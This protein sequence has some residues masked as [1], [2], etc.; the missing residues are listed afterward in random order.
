MEL[1]SF[2]HENT[3]VASSYNVQ[4]TMLLCKIQ[5]KKCQQKYFF[6]H[7]NVVKRSGMLAERRN[8]KEAVNITRLFVPLFIAFER[9][10]C[11]S[12]T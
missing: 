12:I 9:R 10:L 11:C 3:I 2:I 8:K 6:L 5:S 4:T 7:N 1:V